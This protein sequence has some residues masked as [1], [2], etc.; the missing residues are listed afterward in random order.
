MQKNKNILSS[1]LLASALTLTPTLATSL[2][3]NLQL[4]QNSLSNTIAKNL[5]RRGIDKTASKKIANRFFSIDEELFALMLKNLQ[6]SYPSLNTNEILHFLTTQALMRKN[7]NLNSYSYL[8]NM[9]HQIKKQTPNK[10]ELAVL[11]AIA[12]KNNN[13][14]LRNI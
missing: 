1:L 8:V 5:H 12:I 11:N 14:Y 9:I 13:L 3:A 6:I 4:S 7:A 10:L 2:S